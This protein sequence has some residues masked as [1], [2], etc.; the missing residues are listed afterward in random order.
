MCRASWSV[1]V[2]HV[3]G[4]RRRWTRCSPRGLGSVTS[5][6]ENPVK[7]IRRTKWIGATGRLHTH[8]VRSLWPSAPPLRRGVALAKRQC[9]LVPERV[10]RAVPRALPIAAHGPAKHE[11]V[12][13]D[14][15]RRP[16][17][18]AAPRPTLTNLFGPDRTRGARMAPT[19]SLYTGLES[20]MLALRAHTA[21]LSSWRDCQFVQQRGSGAVRS[22]QSRCSC[23]TPIRGA[24]IHPLTPRSRLVA[25]VTAIALSACG[26]RLS[27]VGDGVVDSDG[28]PV[29]LLVSQGALGL[30]GSRGCHCGRMDIR[31]DPSS[32][33][34]RPSVGTTGNRA[35]RNSG[36]SWLSSN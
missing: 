14:V 35:D 12:T 2:S 10:T 36:F 3:S 29:I 33:I 24:I 19:V 11:G 18:C 5:A 25:T 20:T 32:R 21:R 28:C 26:A 4:Q 23:R 16:P 1:D 6:V 13:C 15:S 8:R 7:R 31:Q 22:G 30:R 27:T 34:T 9:P 17:S